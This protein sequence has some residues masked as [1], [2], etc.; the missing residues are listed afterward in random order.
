M[1]CKT[2]SSSQKG[3]IGRLP[4]LSREAKGKSSI[5]SITSTMRARDSMYSFSSNA[6]FILHIGVS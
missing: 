4:D 3:K 5:V 1:V 6:K 2:E